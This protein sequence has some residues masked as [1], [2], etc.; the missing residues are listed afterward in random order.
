MVTYYSRLCKL[1]EELQGYLTPPCSCPCSCGSKALIAKEHDDERTHQFLIGL[2][3]TQYSHVQSNMLMQD[4]I[5]SLNMVF[6][7]A[8]TE[9]R[10][11][12]LV[13]STERKLEATGFAVQGPSRS[14][15]FK[16]RGSASQN[17]SLTCT[18]YHQTGHNQQHCFE[19]I[20]YPEW[21]YAKNLRT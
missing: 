18:H 9:E 14:H 16:G 15:P 11:L 2:D 19:L 3:S 4:L 5:P 12:A 21:W 20:G 17:N 10:N 6:S 7:K 8:I 13:H 1:W